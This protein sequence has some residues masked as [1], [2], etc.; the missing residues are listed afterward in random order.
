M[1]FIMSRVYKFFAAGDGAATAKLL[2]GLIENNSL[3]ASDPRSFNDPF[4]CKVV[5]DLQAPLEIRRA[6]FVADNPDKSQHEFERWNIGLP[7][8]SWS[9]E[10]DVRASILSSYGITCFTHNWELELFWAHYAK[11]HTGFCVAFDQ[12]KLVS[13]DEAVGRGNVSYVSA[14]PVFKFL[15]QQASI[16]A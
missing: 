2:V 1:G 12:E 13:W 6:R 14:A 7:Q 3:R 10:Q 4:E 8:A 16:C 11:N 5:L 15:R 9:I